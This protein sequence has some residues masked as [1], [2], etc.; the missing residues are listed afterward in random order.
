MKRFSSI[1]L[2][3]VLGVLAAASNL[4]AQNYNGAPA[5]ADWQDAVTW[6]TPGTWPGRFNDA[7]TAEISGAGIIN[8]ATPT[9]R[10]R[11]LRIT[12]TVAAAVTFNGT[13]TLR[14]GTLIIDAPIALNIG[15][16]MTL[17]VDSLIDGN[18]TA[19]IAIAA[20]AV[21]R[22][23]NT[24]PN[25]F[26]LGGPRIT[27]VSPAARVELG[28]GYNNNVFPAELFAAAGTPGSGYLGAVEI[29]STMRLTDNF[30][31]GATSGPMILSNNALFTVAGGVTLTLNQTA[32]N[33][34]QGNGRFQSEPGG[35][36]LIA[37]G[38]NAGDLPGANFANPFF[39]FLQLAGA[40]RLTSDFTLGA[41]NGTPQQ[42][43]IL[44]LNAAAAIL[45][46]APGVTLR[47][48]SSIT[49]AVRGT[50]NIQ[51]Q[52]GANIILGNGFNQGIL[53]GARIFNI[54]G[55]LTT[56]GA[57]EANIVGNFT[58]LAQTGRLVIG[59]NLNLIGAGS[60]V[61]RNTGAGS[62]SRAATAPNAVISAGSANS[63]VQFDVG[64]NNGLIPGNLFSN[65]FDGGI[66]VTAP[67]TL[68]G[69]LN[70]GSASGPLHL[71]NFGTV[72]TIGAN[73]QLALRR[74]NVGAVVNSRQLLGPGAVPVVEAFAAGFMGVSRHT[75][76][77]GLNSTSR[78]VL[79]AGFNG[80]N[81]P[82]ATIV[83]GAST[84]AA[85]VAQQAF[86]PIPISSNG[87]VQ[88]FRGT[89]VLEGSLTFNRDV[90]IDPVGGLNLQGGNYTVARFRTLELFNQGT[91]SLTGSGF[92]QGFAAAN[93]AAA[94]DPSLQMTSL[95][96]DGWPFPVVG[97]TNNVDAG[98]GMGAQVHIEVAT[99]PFVPADN[100]AA[101]PLPLRPGYLNTPLRYMFDRATRLDGRLPAYLNAVGVNIAGAGNINHL[102]NRMLSP[103]MPSVVALGPGFN[104]GTIPARFFASPFQG[105]L[106]VSMAAGSVLGLEGDLVMGIPGGVSHLVVGNQAPGG[107]VANHSTLVP[108]AAGGPLTATP[109]AAAAN[110]LVRSNSSITFNGANVNYYYGCP[111]DANPSPTSPGTLQGVD[112]TSRIIINPGV[113]SVPSGV[114]AP[115][116]PNTIA[117]TTS[118]TFLATPYNGRLEFAGNAVINQDL[119]IGSSGALF[120]GGAVTV[121]TATSPVVPGAGNTQSRL[122]EY[123]RRLHGTGT[124]TFLQADGTL[125]AGVIPATADQGRTL[126]PLGYTI[127]LNNQGA[128]TILGT[129]T[130]LAGTGNTVILGAGFNGGVLPASRFANPYYGTL[131]TVSPLTMNGVL[132]IGS[133]VDNAT[134]NRYLGHYNQGTPGA[135]SQFVQIVGTMLEPSSGGGS[136]SGFLRLG[137]RLTISAGSLLI[138]SNATVDP[139]TGSADGVLQAEQGG[140]IR[141]VDGY[142]SMGVNSLTGYNGMNLNTHTVRFR[143][144][145][146]PSTASGLAGS[147]PTFAPKR[148]GQA[149]ADATVNIAAPTRSNFDARYFASPFNGRL[150]L[151]SGITGTDGFVI[152]SPGRVLQNGRSVFRMTSGTLT[153]GETGELNLLS[154]LYLC[155]TGNGNQTAAGTDNTNEIPGQGLTYPRLVLNNTRANSF[156]GATTGSVLQSSSGT[157]AQQTGVGSPFFPGP[158]AALPTNP[159][160]QEYAMTAAGGEVVLGSGFNAGII[161]ANRFADAGNENPLLRQFGGTL[162]LPNTGTLNLQGDFV[163]DT[164]N[165][166]LTPVFSTL[167]NF[168]MLNLGTGSGRLIV[169][170]GSSITLGNNGPVTGPAG[171][172]PNYAATTPARPAISGSGQLGGASNNARIILGKT[173]GAYNGQGNV[174]LPPAGT[175]GFPLR[176]ISSITAANFVQPFVGRLVITTSGSL[177]SAPIA[178][179][180]NGSFTLGAPGSTDGI[181]DVQNADGVLAI[182]SGDTLRINNTAQVST[183]L[184]GAGRLLALNNQGFLVLGQ[185]SLTN[186][187]PGSKLQNP[188]VGT[189][190]TAPGTTP[191]TLDA[192]FILAGDAPTDGT[193]DL[194]NG[195]LSL[196]APLR[197]LSGVTLGFNN[198]RPGAL[199]GSGQLQATDQTSVVRLCTGF[200]GYV[201]PGN[202]FSNP[203]NGTILANWHDPAGTP[204]VP[205]N[206][207]ATL[208]MTQTEFG[209]YTNPYTPIANAVGGAGAYYHLI[210]NLTIGAPGSANGFLDLRGNPAVAATYPIAGDLFLASTG[211]TVGVING[212]TIDKRTTV[213]TLTVNNILPVAQVL[214]GAGLIQSRGREKGVVYVPATPDTGGGPVADTT[215]SRMLAATSLQ[216]NPLSSNLILG[217]NAL[218]NVFPA[219]KLGPI[220]GN[221]FTPPSA[222]T[223]DAG[224]ITFT[225]GG[226]LVVGGLTATIGTAASLTIPNGNIYTFLTA[227]AGALTGIGQ[228]I[229]GNTSSTISF[230][231]GATPTNRGEIPARNI[232]PHFNGQLQIQDATVMTLRNGQLRIGDG[233]DN[234]GRLQIG[235]L[236]AVANNAQLVIGSN[237][238]LDLRQQNPNVILSNSQ[239][240]IARDST[241]KLILGPS[242]NRNRFQAE[243]LLAGGG[244]MTNLV[245]SPFMGVLI[246]STGSLTLNNNLVIGSDLPAYPSPASGGAQ[247][248]WLSPATVTPPRGGL[249]LGGEL[250]IP[251]GV[252]LTY[253]ATTATSFRGTLGSAG[254][255]NINPAARGATP[256]TGLY[257]EFIFNGNDQTGGVARANGGVVPTQLF[258]VRAL[259]VAT[260]TLGTV[261]FNTNTARLTISRGNYE[262]SNSN[263]PA[264]ATVLRMYGD[265]QVGTATRLNIP[266]NSLL[267]IL[268]AFNPAAVST[269]GF[270]TNSATNRGAITATDSTGTLSF[271]RRTGTGGLGGTSPAGNATLNQFT[272]TI[273]ADAAGFQGRLF[274]SARQLVVDAVTVT[275]GTASVLENFNNI[276]LT[277]QAPTLNL[278]NQGAN[279]FRG[280]TI[281]GEAS[282]YFDANSDAT[283]TQ[284]GFVASTSTTTRVNLGTN[285]NAGILPGN[286]FGAGGAAFVGANPNNTLPRTNPFQGRITIASDQTLSSRLNIGAGGGFDFGTGT[287]KLIV[288]SFGATDEG[289]LLNASSARYFVTNS[290]GY[291]A[292]G[293]VSNVTFPVGPSTAIYSPLFIANNSAPSVFGVRANTPIAPI[294]VPAAATGSPVPQSSVGIRWSVEQRNNIAAGIA[295]ALSPQ[296][297]TSQQGGGF[298]PAIAVVNRYTGLVSSQTSVPSQAA[299]VPNLTNYFQSSIVVSQTAAPGALTTSTELI[300]TSQP[301]PAILSF[302][303]AA[304]ASS[305]TVTIV[306]QRFVNVTAVRFGGTNAASFTVT[307]AGD[308][309][310][311]VVGQGTTGPVTVVQTG[312][313]ATSATNFTYLGA[314]PQLPVIRDARPNPIFAGLGDVQITIIGTGFGSQTLRVNASGSGAQGTITPISNSATAITFVLP[315]QFSRNV[316]TVN[317][318][319]TS[320]DKLP[321]STTVTVS[322]APATTLTSITPS[323]TSGNLQAH[324]VFVTGSAFGPQS[325]FSLNGTSLR[326][327][328]FTTNTNGTLTAGVEIPVGAVSGNVVVTNLNNTTAQL[329]FSITNLPRPVITG[330]APL[331]IA[332]GSPATLVTISGLNLIPGATVSFNGFPITG[333]TTSSTSI[334]FVVPAS[335]LANPDLA[336]IR[337]TNPDNQSVGYRF[338]ISTGVGGTDT[339]VIPGMP[340]PNNPS[341]IR[342]TPGTV[343]PGTTTATGQAF[344]LTINGGNISTNATVSLGGVALTIVR[345]SPTQIVANVPASANVAGMFA[346]Q[347][348]NSPNAITTVTY[349]IGAA[350]QGPAISNVT[351]QGTN[352]RITGDNFGQ[353]ATVQLGSERLTVVSVSTTAIV[354]VA[355]RL[356]NGNY[357]LVVTNPDGQFAS[358]LFALVSV[359][360]ERF[361]GT[362]MYPNPTVDVVNVEATLERSAEVVITI[363]NTLGQN[364]M[365]VRQN[366]SA[367]FFTKS[368]NIQNLPTGAYTVE[369]TDGTRRSV[370]KIIKN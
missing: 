6:N 150:T 64:F 155:F 32:L 39:G 253:S 224:D 93:A 342:P 2:V 50:G 320:T 53:P 337:V 139:L 192:N 95:G 12:N 102:G 263:T 201:I 366:V 338:P 70:L 101:A 88:A 109:T 132:Q 145:D 158:A 310:R 258:G 283:A 117:Y 48:N 8:N 305:Q 154:P 335:L 321:V 65:P 322:V 165:R 105:T 91:N 10:V 238:T 123:G 357:T 128:N 228:L 361:A 247:A 273:G 29:R 350:A 140:E 221:V 255:I 229:A 37:A 171:F 309:I 180:L 307:A 277:G 99:S 71:S 206:P 325:T 233:T 13:G 160:A 127:R 38:F 153:I 103:N 76:I 100:A 256:A 297:P 47:L 72:L 205:L 194:V 355:P 18:G 60:L 122:A 339:P 209:D 197:L 313:T 16:G 141:L 267:E 59:G 80:G 73:S 334:Q 170:D 301:Q 266:R 362:R 196:N 223:A 96:I 265:L 85:S 341:I 134:R 292:L 189:L 4:Q 107:A 175:P 304:A 87:T 298:N 281:L 11:S 231:G 114:V 330:I 68:E 299:T 15:A 126:N 324:T 312:G 319:V 306:G 360:R 94:I 291:A 288:G 239:P 20:G 370:E 62:L 142:N 250:I 268:T 356:P 199:F 79:G 218:N 151:G 159:V 303:P 21:L 116:V 162:S 186:A 146:W 260:T 67:L 217:Q 332:P 333:V 227:H 119:T 248:F 172:A 347:I 74:T 232:G 219:A 26:V 293:Q 284:V 143:Y 311:A 161:Q 351:A 52:V 17:E 276:L 212:T 138:V 316:G 220:T 202:R 336:T 89:L 84:D 331:A 144:P 106:D 168:G 290:T 271:F 77:Q 328:S 270:Q 78:L 195:R 188:F 169:A 211:G 235:S 315:G 345:V 226:T 57:F 353:G 278:N 198:F 317:L 98:V 177:P 359:Q 120:L 296:W 182:G 44:N 213:A 92:I 43:G 326:I 272:P 314:P 264:Q 136:S 254:Y 302:T 367:G 179:V 40:A 244:T 152:P 131:A 46:V 274:I 63:L 287:A 56:E 257:G 173:I 45:T 365:T 246:T 81:A 181:L 245:G 83:P 207:H 204:L 42:Q 340:D 300:V 200:N 183:V 55:T 240:I 243:T 75:Y 156:V 167:Y 90:R 23:T 108:V 58:P 118:G 190:V 214:P 41:V 9:N 358:Q 137:A 174:G 363:S 82:T 249:E 346:L 280:S 252:T 187:V 216:L 1:L 19:T 176:S 133:L 135:P 286:R 121:T 184:P 31:R 35:T 261:G 285:F 164:P 166:G 308:T 34:L 275:M 51:A 215:N 230:G 282:A 242:F 343:V 149:I 49:N 129:G 185:G 163:F 352:L 269:G 354:V 225:G 191:L 110:I 295:V 369:I 124:P 368:L 364:V 104:A 7:V 348:A 54:E 130:L 86:L 178:T 251:A 236:N 237:A 279:S 234:S 294:V 148:G 147:I 97:Y 112:A 22:V 14:I 30:Q 5:M 33:S 157:F 208:S 329:P 327:M 61:F 66:T 25:A 262:L 222:V 349:T 289:E 323:T 3:F 115:V 241:S 69:Q 344:Q 36:I 318:T 259:D 28:V 27:S 210:G 111:I 24:N 125:W 193:D 203:W 113:G